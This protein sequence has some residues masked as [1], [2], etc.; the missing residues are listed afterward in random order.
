MSVYPM[1]IPT[2]GRS[3]EAIN[4]VQLRLIKIKSKYTHSFGVQPEIESN[5]YIGSKCICY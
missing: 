3:Y 4:P 1:I 5:S 2:E